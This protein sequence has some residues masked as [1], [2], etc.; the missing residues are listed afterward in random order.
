ME[1]KQLVVHKR[2]AQPDNT[3]YY[4]GGSGGMLFLCLLVFLLRKLRPEQRLPFRSSPSD[5]TG[6]R[7]NHNHQQQIFNRVRK[8]AYHEVNPV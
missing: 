8:P 1:S 5:F 6:I 4:I 2:F 3:M 7:I